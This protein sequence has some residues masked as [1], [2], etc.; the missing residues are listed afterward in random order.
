MGAREA[1]GRRGRI[2]G[3][4]RDC[5]AGPGATRAGLGVTVF[6]HSLIPTDLQKVEDRLGL[7]ALGGCD[8]R[9]LANPAAPRAAVE[10][11][12]ASIR[13]A[14]LSASGR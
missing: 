8:F 3:R 11:L 12:T 6:A 9:L 2:A 10:S 7:P 13:S 4:G 5:G 14:T 1:A